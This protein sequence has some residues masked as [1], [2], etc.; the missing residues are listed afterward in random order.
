MD[1]VPSDSILIRR[2]KGILATLLEDVL[3][4]L[5]E[6]SCNI[7]LEEKRARASDLVEWGSPSSK[8][9]LLLG[10]QHKPVA[11]KVF[12]ASAKKAA[13]TRSTRRYPSIRSQWS[14][15]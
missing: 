3:D 1:R 4:D 9:G 5:K 11:R 7:R 8:E 13:R 14:V 15:P 10:S 6:I 2:H 12:A